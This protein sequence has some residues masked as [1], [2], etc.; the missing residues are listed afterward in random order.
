[1]IWCNMP[2]RPLLM[3]SVLSLL[4]TLGLYGYAVM[5]P[6]AEM[7]GIGPDAVEGA[8]VR[9][10]GLVGGV[11]ALSNG[12]LGAEILPGGRPPG[13][14]LYVPPE[15]DAA[16][17]VRAR[18]L[19]GSVVRVEGRLQEYNGKL[20]VVLDHAHEL[21]LLAASSLSVAWKRP[22]LLANASVCL[23]G[24]AFYKQIENG[25]LSFRLMDPTDRSCELN[26]TA[27]SYYPDDEKA[28][29]GNGTS[30]RVMGRMRYYGEPPIPRLSVVGG[31]GGVE[32]PG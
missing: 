14:R 3:V 31:A 19:T 9:V 7:T 12:A 30:V 13:V 8:Y 11:N 5:A 6:P 24:V 18:L 2:D 4:G 15:L 25:R 29:W 10:E 22:D 1:M 16:G 23:A 32:P 21:R 27:A 20:E 26:C 17:A 28:P